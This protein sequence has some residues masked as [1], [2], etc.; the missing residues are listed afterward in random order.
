MKFIAYKTKASD[1]WRKFAKMIYELK[2]NN[3][4]NHLASYIKLFM[5][6]LK[7]TGYSSQGMLTEKGIIFAHE[8]TKAV[9][10]SLP[11]P[12]RNHNCIENYDEYIAYKK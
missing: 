8:I 7:I 2:C 6:I 3:H 12:I 5:W 10:E 11:L 9:V 4:K 1:E